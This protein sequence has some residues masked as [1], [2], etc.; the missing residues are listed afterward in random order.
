MD[1]GKLLEKLSGIEVRAFIAERAENRKPWDAVV[2]ALNRHYHEPDIQAAR[3]L[4]SGVAAHDLK[5]QPVWP[6]A[7]APP[8]SMKTEL[9]RAL[10]G[11]DRVH[12]IDSVT[13]KTFISGQIQDRNEGGAQG[14]PSSL[15]H[16]IGANGIVL[17]G[18]FSTILS[19]KA[20]ER[21]GILAD[22]RRIYDGELRKEFG[23]S[24]ATPPWKGRMTLVVAVT[25]AIDKHY[26]VL[27][28]LG[29]RFVMVRMGRGGQQAAI[30]AMTQDVEK[31][32]TE[33]R[34]AVHGLFKS[35]TA[36]E[37]AVSDET[38]NRLAAMAEFAVRARS[39]VPR[40]GP[41]KAVV[42]EPQPESAARLGQQL[43]QL[44]KGSARLS[45]R[46]LVNDED[47]AVAR[48]V[49]FDC[50]P[51]RRRAMLEVA[52][53]GEKIVTNTSTKKYDK[54]D[55]EVLGLLEG[56]S[57]S[58]LAKELLQ[59]IDGER[60]TG[61]PPRTSDQISTGTDLGVGE[62]SGEAGREEGGQ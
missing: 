11:L 55:L 12:S 57:L 36:V 45:H 44:A 25:E 34:T 7:V 19:I 60:L 10:D 29:D 62:T 61:S 42:G 8:S 39:S 38:T 51:A 32:R 47:F 18:D 15:L 30:R 31:A 23:T 14:R 58:L 35:L 4:Y 24:E 40:E 17:C 43:S 22:L 41:D 59:E 26:S 48:R 33:L 56:N 6:M 52:I 28:S 53:Q 3:A 50:I 21:N 13:A 46:E 54:E 16:R 27:Q 5:G 20:D 37:P 1:I 49:A 2:A 9:I